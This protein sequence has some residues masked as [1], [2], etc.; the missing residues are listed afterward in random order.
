MRLE[1]GW[2]SDGGLMEVED[3]VAQCVEVWSFRCVKWAVLVIRT[4]STAHLCTRPWFCR[5]FQICQRAN[6]D[7]SHFGKISTYD[8]RS[9]RTGHPVRSAIHKH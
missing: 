6:F 1:K 5:T 2:R 7:K 4:A 8:H 9:V 3:Q